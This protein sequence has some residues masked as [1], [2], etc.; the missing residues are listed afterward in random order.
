MAP[1][2]STI[3]YGALLMA[4]TSP[5][6]EK[7]YVLGTEP[8]DA[9]ATVELIDL[10][11]TGLASHLLDHGLRE[12]MSGIGF[13]CIQAENAAADLTTLPLWLA[14]EA[15]QNTRIPIATEPGTDL[16][17]IIFASHGDIE[18][19]LSSAADLHGPSLENTVLVGRQERHGRSQARTRRV[20]GIAG[21]DRRDRSSWHGGLDASRSRRGGTGL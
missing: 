17:A 5:Y 6:V 16:G 21:D 1:S 20:R 13:S 7:R 14:T 2:T 10:E 8:I 3:D 4:M 18:Q 11:T 19:L 12:D 9:N 15:W